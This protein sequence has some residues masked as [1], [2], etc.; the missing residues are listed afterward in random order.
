VLNS[1]FPGSQRKGGQDWIL[2]LSGIEHSDLKRHM[3]S[4]AAFEVYLVLGTLT[5]KSVSRHTKTTGKALPVDVAL[6]STS[7]RAIDARERGCGFS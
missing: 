6:P 4:L 3:P 5:T 1:E 2:L 7:P